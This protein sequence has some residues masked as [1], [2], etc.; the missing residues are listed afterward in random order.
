M[1]KDY[2]LKKKKN[3]IGKKIHCIIEN[4][5]NGQK[6]DYNPSCIMLVFWLVIKAFFLL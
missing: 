5:K 4:L 6:K 2:P 3:P 1:L